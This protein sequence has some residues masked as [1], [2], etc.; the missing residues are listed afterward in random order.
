MLYST[1][2]SKGDNAIMPTYRANE[3]SRHNAQS[4]KQ[5]EHFLAIVYAEAAEIR[6]DL[7]NYR[8]IKRTSRFEEHGEFVEGTLVSISAYDLTMSTSRVR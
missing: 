5:R 3:I 2:I 8:I 4:L 1:R 7:R 6:H